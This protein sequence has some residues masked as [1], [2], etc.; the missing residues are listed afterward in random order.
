MAATGLNA[1]GARF[2]SGVIG[3][4]ILVFIGFALYI[5]LNAQKGLPFV[6][7]GYYKIAVSD[8]GDLTVGNDVRMNGNRVGR[9]NGIYLEDRV[10]IVE[11]QIDDV[12]TRIFRNGTSEVVS[13]SGLGQKY[14]D[15]QPGTPES[16]E[17]GQNET[18][19]ATPGKVSTQLLDLAQ[20]FD[21]ATQ[22][23]AQTTLRE[24]GGG[25]A[26]RGPDLADF[27]TAAPEILPD[28][29][30]VSRSLSVDDGR[31]LTAM[32]R[33]LERLSSR[34]EG[35]AQE[36]TELEEQLATTLAAFNAD[37]GDALGRTLD[38]A[39]GALASTRGALVDLEQ[40]LRDTNR[41]FTDIEPAAESLA[42]AEP[43]LRGF[44]RE[45]PG[46]LYK[47]PEASETGQPALRS[48]SSVMHDARPFAAKLRELGGFA[49]DPL[50]TLRPYS[51]ELAGWFSSAANALSDGDPAGH[52]LRFSVLPRIES[53]SGGGG[54]EDPLRQGDAYPGPGEVPDQ[55]ANPLAPP[56]PTPENPLSQGVEDNGGPA[57]P[58]FP[59]APEGLLPGG[60]E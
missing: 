57:A 5:A 27:A 59:E 1:R 4:V 37:G 51:P 35:R 40:P 41:A 22:A 16:G 23:A 54:F 50:Q 19:P 60:G 6:P 55:R 48:L 18:L 32:L 58:E 13:R 8:A 44:L 25:F 14:L 12:E 20:V 17:L 11:M 33:S 31:D 56:D 21:P 43:D 39:P 7:H 36:I 3:V 30:T 29:G 38:A 10:A 28:L 2:R 52:W 42:R 47:L 53:V 26:A 45:A 46:P 9:V 15:V 34:F 24:L 49:A